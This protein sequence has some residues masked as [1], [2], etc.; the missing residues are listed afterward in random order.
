MWHSLA[1]IAQ[2]RFLNRDKFIA[3]ANENE[4][5]YGIVNGCVSTWDCD[6]LIEG[7]RKAIGEDAYIKEAAEEFVRQRNQ[8]L[9]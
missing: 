8:R 9:V 1:V 7:Y 4:G 3:F 5:I 6:K 2:S